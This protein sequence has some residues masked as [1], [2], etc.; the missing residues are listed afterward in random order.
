VISTPFRLDFRRNPIYDATFAGIHA[1]WAHI[2]PVEYVIWDY[3]GDASPVRNLLPSAPAPGQG[4]PRI[5]GLAKLL[6]D[7]TKT[8]AP[9]DLLYNDGKVAVFRVRGLPEKWPSFP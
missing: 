1:P 7:A 2:P 6:I 3:A 8:G 5:F 9:G 4:S